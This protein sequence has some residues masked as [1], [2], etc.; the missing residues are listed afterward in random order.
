MSS[1]FSL[2]V[3]GGPRLGDM[4]SGLVAGLVGAL[5][6]V[7]IGGI[8]CIVGVGVTVLAFPELAAYE[9]DTAMELM[10]SETAAADGA[11][12]TGAPI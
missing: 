9:A 7:V 3:T 4:E 5:N 1:V 8:G 11:A 2:V 12:V 6:S 10:L